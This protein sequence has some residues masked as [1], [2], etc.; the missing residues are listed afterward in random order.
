MIANNITIKRINKMK[1]LIAMLAAMLPFF[2]FFGCSEEDKEEGISLLSIDL[3][4]SEL[5]VR[6][7]DTFQ[8]E[9]TTTPEGFQ[10]DKYEWKVSS[11][12]GKGNGYIDR[13]GLF[14]GTV[15]GEVYVEVSTPN[16]LNAGIPVSDRAIVKV[17]ERPDDGDPDEEASPITDISFNP[18][19]VNMKKGESAS[20]EYSVQPA[21]ADV[22]GLRW[23]TTDGSVAA[24]ITTSDG[25]VSFN[26]YA[27]G[28]ADI[29]TTVNG[30]RFA[31]HV[32]VEPV[33]AESIVLRETE[34]EIR[35]RGTYQIEAEIYPEDA[36]NKE[37][38][39]ASS[40]NNVA[41]VSS[42]GKVIGQKPG[43]CVIT[44]S[45]SDGK[46]ETS[47][48][49]T[50][51]EIPLEDQIRVSISGSSMSLGGYVTGSFFAS[52]YNYSDKNINVKSFSIYDTSTNERKYRKEDLGDL[53][54]RQV[55]STNV[56]L[57]NIYQPL[58]VW[59]YECEGKTYQI[60]HL[61]E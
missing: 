22:S 28:E 18:T 24:I 35:E 9:V 1:K 5:S 12:D 6:V 45:T 60:S 49:V 3:N 11:K 21:G 56:R 57:S 42:G 25:K 34:V 53:P 27:A 4:K 7:G 39:Y 50:V 2:V 16:I 17:T 47:M 52:L 23:D 59:E 41:T 29:F 31:F 13:N 44:V 40:D 54:T 38:T 15:V 46:A 43:E 30:K 61:Y 8:F 51:T 20:V 10:V 19:T 14:T 33:Y 58:F 37:L 55:L 36:D 32:M 48:K 26:S